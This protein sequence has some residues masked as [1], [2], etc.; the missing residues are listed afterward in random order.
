MFSTVDFGSHD[1]NTGFRILRGWKGGSVSSV[2][3]IGVSEAMQFLY[4]F[5]SFWNPEQPCDFLFLVLGQKLSIILSMSPN[6]MQLTKPNFR[7]W[8]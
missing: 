3:G 5:I 1:T 2:G 7:T 6:A 8:P 4:F